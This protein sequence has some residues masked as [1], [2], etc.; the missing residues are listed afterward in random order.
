MFNSNVQPKVRKIDVRKEPW[1]CL[2]CSAENK[3]YMVK[4]K[5][6]GERRPH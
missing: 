5:D 4:C 2:K 3:H 6:C 1:D